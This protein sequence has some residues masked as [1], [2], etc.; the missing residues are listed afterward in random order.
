MP[1]AAKRGLGCLVPET[2]PPLVVRTVSDYADI[3]CRACSMLRLS[4]H[5]VLHDVYCVYDGPGFVVV[6]TSA[7]ITLTVP[8]EETG[9]SCWPV[10]VDSNPRKFHH[11]TVPWLRT[12]LEPR[13]VG[14]F[15]IVSAEGPTTTTQ[16][17][18]TSRTLHR[19]I[20]CFRDGESPS[21]PSFVPFFVYGKLFSPYFALVGVDR[22]LTRYMR[23]STVLTQL[24]PL[25]HPSPAPIAY[26][27]G[28]HEESGSSC[29]ILEDLTSRVSTG[30]IATPTRNA[31]GGQDNTTSSE[32]VQ[33]VKRAMQSLA[34]F[35]GQWMVA[36]PSTLPHS[37]S[38]NNSDSK[39]K[40]LYS[41]LVHPMVF[42]S[43]WKEA[44]D[45]TLSTEMEDNAAKTACEAV[46][47]ESGKRSTYVAQLPASHEASAFGLFLAEEA[48]RAVYDAPSLP[49]LVIQA[50]ST[51]H[52]HGTEE[53]SDTLASNEAVSPSLL[54]QRTSVAPEWH[55]T[56]AS[57]I[58]LIHGA[59]HDVT[60]LA[61]LKDA[62]HTP[63]CMFLDWKDSGIG[64]V[65]I[66]LVDVCVSLLTLADLSNPTTMHG[67]LEEYCACLEVFHGVKR[68]AHQMLLSC[69][70]IS[71]LRCYT[72]TKLE[73]YEWGASTKR[74][75]VGVATALGTACGL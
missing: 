2:W 58:S 55:A 40:D 53:S 29:S 15:Q 22:D 16:S 14:A 23:E 68:D 17:S 51:L 30:V 52:S 60:H 24:L 26:Y 5:G 41:A 21:E 20:R 63:N 74:E 66:D 4:L 6:L 61:F 25:C 10:D 47:A 8:Q 59:L 3:Q 32:N 49:S 34:L 13:S 43:R 19:R 1:S 9:V 70:D 46:A 45:Q 28:F 38:N 50:G 71:R 69:R 64:P 12:I 57:S 39:Q 62:R 75:M 36:S 27:Y 65:E 18:S 11:I 35:H 48:L 31:G 54:S 72:K 42:F 73:G 33:L 37:S 56:W 44:L 67:L 7:G